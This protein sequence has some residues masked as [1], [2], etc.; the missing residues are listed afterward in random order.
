MRRTARLTLEC[1]EERQLL[2]YTITDLGAALPAAINNAGLVAG[3]ANSHAVVQRDG[4]VTDLGTL[5]GASSAA[6][7][8][9]ELGQVVGSA[10]APDG[11]SH[12]FLVTPEDTNN[13]GSPD[14]W[15]RD[16]DL[17]GI[18]DLMLDLGTL[19]GPGSRAMGINNLGQVVGRADTSTAAGSYRAFVWDSAT[20]H[21]QQRLRGRLRHADLRTGRDDQDHHG[22]GQRRQE[23]GS[24]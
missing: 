21:E 7:D 1:L 18:N 4:V 5:G 14:L 15:F 20:D 13:D 6:N 10:T 22:A 24:E 2:S 12:A 23:K 3:V 8:I 16:N 11:Y 17:N 19:G 9:N